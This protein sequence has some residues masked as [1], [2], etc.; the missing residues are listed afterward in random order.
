[1][2]DCPIVRISKYLRHSDA[3]ASKHYDFGVIEA[4]ARSRQAISQLLGG[5]KFY[6]LM[7]GGTIAGTSKFLVH[8]DVVQVLHYGHGEASARN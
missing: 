3:V 8:S 2:I 1:M 6:L 4:S 7:I 5:M